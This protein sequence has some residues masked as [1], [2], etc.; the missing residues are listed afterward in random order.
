MLKIKDHLIK[1]VRKQHAE[2]AS[3]NAIEKL[4]KILSEKIRSY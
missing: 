4:I 2:E 1:T 3:G